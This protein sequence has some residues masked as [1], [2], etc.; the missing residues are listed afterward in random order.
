MFGVCLLTYN[1]L[2]YAQRALSSLSKNGNLA[3]APL[4]EHNDVLLV[5]ADDGSPSTYRD[6]LEDHA[7]YLGW[8][9]IE[10]TNSRRGGYGKN[11][12]LATQVLHASCDAVLM[13]EDDWELSRS[14]DFEPLVKLVLQEWNGVNI[15]CVRLGYLGFTQSL[16][17]DLIIANNDI[18]LLF[19]PASAEPHVFT[20]HPRIESVKFQRHV[21]VWPEGHSPGETEMIVANYSESRHGVVW[22]LNLVKP[23]GDLFVHIG[24]IRSTEVG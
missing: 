22:P 7:R 6:A 2:E 17:G 12:N 23:S 15:G 9:N 3:G 18:Y 13:L 14:V 20:G 10:T 16:F 1:R 5:I 19:D 4:T 11:L 8:R 21:G 24:T